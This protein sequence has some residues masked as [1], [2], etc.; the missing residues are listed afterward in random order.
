LIIRLVESK[1]SGEVRNCDT[2]FEE[3]IHGGG[4]T[5]LCSMLFAGVNAKNQKDEMVYS[6]S[7]I[8]QLYPQMATSSV[9]PLG[10]PPLPTVEAVVLG[11]LCEGLGIGESRSVCTRCDNQGSQGPRL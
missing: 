9:L 1:N 11:A 7:F 2:I 4:F 10:S 6:S 3:R 5:S 8:A